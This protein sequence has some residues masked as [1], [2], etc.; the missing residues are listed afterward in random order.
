MAPNGSWTF[1]ALS[2]P[3]KREPAAL[4]DIVLLPQKILLWMPKVGL[5]AVSLLDV[6]LLTRFTGRIMAVPST[7]C[8][9][10]L[11]TVL[12]ICGCLLSQDGSNSTRRDL[13]AVA[14]TCRSLSEPAFDTLWHTIH[15]VAPLL[16]T[17]PE[18]LCTTAPY[19]SSSATNGAPLLRSVSE[20]IT[21]SAPPYATQ[22]RSQLV[23]T[24][25]VSAHLNPRLGWPCGGY[26]SS[27]GAE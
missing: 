1:S 3:L 12:L 22:G 10:P 15:T 27:P 11:E 18:D 14:L 4:P 9:L 8:R 13:V 26:P 20:I 19:V 16:C 6:L 21:S 7:I 23:S 24:A 5:L 17:L 2:F 25:F